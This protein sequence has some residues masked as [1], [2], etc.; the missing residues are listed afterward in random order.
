MKKLF[1]MFTA[2]T[3]LVGCSEAKNE[4]EKVDSVD[5]EDLYAYEVEDHA[6]V[7]YD[8]ESQMEDN[9]VAVIILQDG[10][11]IAIELYPEFAPNT[12]NNFIYLANEKNF[13]DEII[14]HRVIED[15][16]IQ[17]GCPY[18]TGLGGPGYEIF[19]EF[20]ENGFTQ[21]TLENRKGT[22]AMARSTN[23]NSAGSQFYIN[24]NDN[25]ALDGKYAV[26]GKVIYGYDK[27][28]EISN[29]KTNSNNKP[30]D[31]VVI[32]S[33]RVDTKGKSYDNPEEIK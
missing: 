13:Y 5:S 29:T 7:T 9:P 10:S 26:F 32:S 11:K 18:G 22:I 15:F 17:A 12:V 24:V 28:L 16:M 31:S 3:L 19:G 21:N 23:P 33:V 27:V 30:V 20:S 25:D 8:V 6:D 14:F 2:I 4:E 1:L